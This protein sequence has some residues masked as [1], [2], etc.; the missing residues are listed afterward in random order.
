[1]LGGMTTDRSTLCRTLDELLEARDFPDYGPNGL[2]VE[3]SAT[4][5]VLA[6][7]T[8]ARRATIAAALAA[9]ADALL[10]H[11]GILW[12]GLQPITGMLA[13]RVRRLLAGDCNLLAYHLPLDAHPE[14][15]NNA[16]ALDRLDALERKPFAAH[17]GRTIGLGGVLGQP[18]AAADLAERLHRLFGH[19]V[20]HCPGGPATIAAVGVVTGGG[21]GFLGDAADAGFDALI[22]GETSEQTWHEAAERGIHCFACGH[23]ATECRAVHALGGRV[24]AELGLEHVALEEHNPL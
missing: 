7:G 15:G 24:A 4:V 11:H 2:Q 22:T 14:H 19:P 21:Q 18:L 16:W 8:T 17:K 10:V 1:M 5:R 9:S 13:G 6:T 20:V 23:H 3:G 12:G